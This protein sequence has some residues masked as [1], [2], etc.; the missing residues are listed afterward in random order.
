GH[1]IPNALPPHPIAVTVT[2]VAGR[3][4]DEAHV[5]PARLA[6]D[7]VGAVHQLQHPLAGEGLTRVTPG[8]IDEV[9]RMKMGIDDHCCLLSVSSRDAHAVSSA[10]P[11]LRRWASASS[12]F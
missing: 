12:T 3:R 2:R 6:V 8:F 9:C 7:H 4:L 1:V 5:D 10:M 11:L